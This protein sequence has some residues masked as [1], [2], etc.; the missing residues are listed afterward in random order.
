[1]QEAVESQTCPHF[2]TGSAM[3]ILAREIIGRGSLFG[4]FDGMDIEA[5]TH[6][7]GAELAKIAARRHGAD[8]TDTMAPV[9]SERCG[10]NPFDIT[11]VLRQAAKFG[12]P[13]SDEKD[14]D[15]HIDQKREKRTLNKYKGYLA[16]I[17]MSQ[18]LLNGQETTF[19]GRLFNSEE[20]EHI[21]DFSY[22]HHRVRLASGV[23]RKIDVLGAAGIEKWACQSKIK[24]AGFYGTRGCS[25]KRDIQEHYE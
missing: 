19:P 18:I 12:T 20:G 1:M 24:C 5:M 10:G 13:V 7:H 11:A 3:S 23:N 6:Y 14:L 16:E 15:R 2:V 21:P 25:R 8:I 4:R 17:H 9:V 22:V